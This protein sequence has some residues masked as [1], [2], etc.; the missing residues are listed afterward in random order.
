MPF[1]LLYNQEG[2]LQKEIKDALQV[3]EEKPPEAIF[4]IPVRLEE[5]DIPERLSDW[6]A[7]DIYDEGGYQHLTRALALRASNIGI[8]PPPKRMAGAEPAAPTVV[9]QAPAPAPGSVRVSPKDG[10]K[11]VWIPP[12]TFQMGCSPGD[13]EC[14][15][16]EE[17]PHPVTISK[18]FWL[19]QTPVTVAAYKRFAS[20]TSGKMPPAPDFNTGWNNG[21]MPIVNV[22]WDEAQAY[23]A[24]AGGRLPT[25]AEWEYAARAGST[26]ARYGAVDEIGWHEGNSGGRAHEV[27]QKRP[28]GFG[29]YDMLGNVWEWVNDWYD[30]RYY[31]RSPSEDPPGPSKKKERVLRGGGW[32]FNPR[33]LRAAYRIRAQPGIMPDVIGFRCAREVVP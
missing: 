24:W 1:A 18:G 25:E 14:N 19:G 15:D 3:A 7:A 22:T 9:V 5:V 16:D 33:I 26:E 23:C 4:I 6:H 13:M 8:S 2:Y 28:N 27:G 29:L 11:Y 30:A 10:L 32:Y 31:E 20:D 12:G 17:P 21:Q